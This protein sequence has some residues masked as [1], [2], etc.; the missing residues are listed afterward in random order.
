[1]N[2]NHNVQY[3]Q[4]K[5]KVESNLDRVFTLLQEKIDLQFTDLN[6]I[7]NKGIL[8]LLRH[9]ILAGGKRLR[10][11]L[12]Y[13]V[14]RSFYST[15]CN[16]YAEE[17]AYLSTAIELIHTYSLV[18]DDLP[19]MDND[20]LRR[21][22]PTSHVLFGEDHAVLIGDT[23]LNLAYEY[24]LLMA[25]KTQL[26]GIGAAREV[27][28]KAGLFGMIGGQ[29]LDINPKKE[30]NEFSYLSHLQ[31]MKTGALLAAPFTAVGTLF[32]LD[33]NKI[34]QLEVFGYQL[35][36]CFQIQDDILDC[37][38]D[39][40]VLGKTI[41]KDEKQEKL[42]YVT[43]FGINQTKELLNKETKQLYRA[44]DKLSSYMDISFFDWLIKQLDQRKK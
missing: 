28:S 4:D 22:K 37:C 7:Q 39:T 35:G 43:Y 36:C 24:L 10:P 17:L 44:L 3:E 38:S 26:N 18:H 13:A 5:I 42:T 6:K 12:V 15:D 27:A 31:E 21:G 33:E 41:N 1:M 14:A 8:S 23:L 11:I 19:C 29:F 16:Q 32:N 40:T 9:P 34:R 25:S 30:K 2:V 20:D